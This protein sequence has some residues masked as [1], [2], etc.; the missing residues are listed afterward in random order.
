MRLTNHLWQILPDAVT[1]H[2]DIKRLNSLRI[3]IANKKIV[4][5]KEFVKNPF[6]DLSKALTS[7]IC[8]MQKEIEA[9]EAKY[10]DWDAEQS[11]DQ[12]YIGS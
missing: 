3:N 10:P 7:D 2:V 6:S 8:L 4:R 9:I 11:R 12:M 5:A 1:K